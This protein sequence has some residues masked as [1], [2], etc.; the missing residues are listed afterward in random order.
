MRVELAQVAGFCMGVRRAMDMALDASMHANGPVYTFGPLIHNPSALSLLEARGIRILEDIPAR[1]QGTVIIRAH[2]VPPQAKERLDRAGF[3]VIDGTCARVVKVQ[4]L[5][6]SHARQGYTCVLIGDRGHPEVKGIMGHAGDR[7]ILISSEADLEGLPPLGKYIILAQTTQDREYFDNLC[8]R[9][10]ERYP[11]GKVFNTICNS[12]NKRQSEVRRLA[13]R[14]D[15]V[16]VVGGRQSA[17]TRRLAE[18]VT[19]SGRPCMAVE[20]EEDLELGWL[21]G[22]KRVGVTAGASTPNWVINRVLREIEAYPGGSESAFMRW[23]LRAL[24]FLH[25]T[26]LCTALAG[27]ALALSGVLMSGPVPPA[28]DI[29]PWRTMASV[30]SLSSSALYLVLSTLM[31]ACFI[32]SMHTLNRLID[33]EASVYNDPLKA[34]F[35]EAHQGTFITTCVLSLL[36]S[37]TAAWALGPPSFLILLAVTMLG[38]LYSVPFIPGWKARRALKD[39][40]GTKALFVAMAWAVVAFLAPLGRWPLSID[41]ANWCIFF[42]VAVLVFMRS[43]LLEV[44]DVQGDKIVGRETLSLILGEHKVLGMV[45]LLAGM[46]VIASVGL[47][48][49]GLVSRLVILFSLPALWFM[50][51]TRTFAGHRFGQNLKMELKVEAGFILFL[52]SVVLGRSLM[53]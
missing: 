38:V 26:N 24:R 47:T 29:V 43:V 45:R 2:G 33:T 34:R 4:M 30:L 48:L 12:T 6:Y 5:A 37:L 16:V 1:G 19:E 28:G 39:L 36:I 51:L 18:I 8:R 52:I 31:A 41:F 10:L 13:D 27:A 3:E 14:V 25:E 15:A 46:L 35:L 42:M 53:G 50:W 9:I 49:A 17:N 7:G 40:P 21:K 23:S 44:I 20:T 22:F 32:F 11:G